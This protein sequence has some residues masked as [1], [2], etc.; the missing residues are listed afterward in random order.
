M[1]PDH[2]DYPVMIRCPGCSYLVPQAWDTCRRCGTMIRAQT[3]VV[4]AAAPVRVGGAPPALP[5]LSPRSD[6]PPR[7]DPTRPNLVDTPPA[8]PIDEFL[9]VGSAT[10]S[11]AA[12]PRDVEHQLPLIPAEVRMTKH[13]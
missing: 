3:P 2:A 5:T 6:A 12:A 9:P 7:P 11:V 8:A 1:S 10:A 13:R 4:A